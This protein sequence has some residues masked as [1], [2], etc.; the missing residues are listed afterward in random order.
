MFCQDLFLISNKEVLSPTA[1]RPAGAE[2]CRSGCGSRRRPGALQTLVAAQASSSSSMSHGSISPVHADSERPSLKMQAG[3][4]PLF[5]LSG[6]DGLLEFRD[7]KIFTNRDK[8]TRL[9]AAIVS[10]RYFLHYRVIREAVTVTVTIGT[11]VLF[12]YLILNVRF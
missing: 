9:E 7:G 1:K 11:A 10:R 8:L 3:W 12:S 2:V 6:N 4:V 5:F